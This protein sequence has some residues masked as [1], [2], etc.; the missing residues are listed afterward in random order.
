MDECQLY[1]ALLE[2]KPPWKVEKVSLDPGKKMVEIYIA[3]EKGSRL[4]CPVCRKECMVYDHLH[5]R[6]WRDLDSIEFMT[7]I[8]ASPPRIS[9]QEHGI[10]EVSLPWAE[11]TSRFSARFETRSISEMSAIRDLTYVRWICLCRI[12]V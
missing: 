12:Q 11:K 4:P 7:F 8:H 3:H 9:C 6:I 2:L 5:E 1:S 10:R